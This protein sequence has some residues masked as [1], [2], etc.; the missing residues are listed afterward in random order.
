MNRLTRELSLLRQQTASVASTTSSTSTGL[1][2]STDHSANHLIS[3]PSHPTPS[4]RHRSSSSLSTRSMNTATT[5]ASGLTGMSGGTVGT[6]GG[7]AGSTVSGIAPARDSALPRGS[8]PRESLSRNG[9]VASRRSGASSP[10]LASSLLQGDHFPNL[11]SHRQSNP[12]QSG[13]PTMSPGSNRSSYVP[14][15]RYEEAAHHRS[16]LEIVKKENES[17]RRRVRELERSLNSRRRSNA[18]RRGSDS[19]STGASVRSAA[20][21]HTQERGSTGNDDE[22]VVNVGES[23]G[24]VGVGGG[25]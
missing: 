15:A 3:G 8:N 17:L 18:N 11:Y 5:T 7:I 22:D 25:H 9:S 10:S 21:G 1:P 23:A 6:T 24:S 2:D 19:T 13:Q 16:E 4:R 12:S 20:V 14:T